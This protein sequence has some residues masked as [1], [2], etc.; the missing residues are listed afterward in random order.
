M[1]AR[2]R[3]L[4]AGIVLSLSI[5]TW[6]GIGLA[7]CPD[8]GGACTGE[9]D[10]GMKNVKDVFGAIECEHGPEYDPDCG[11]RPRCCEQQPGGCTGAADECSCFGCG[12]D[13][14][15]ESDFNVWVCGCGQCTTYGFTRPAG[16]G[17]PCD[18]CKPA[19][20]ADAI[21]FEARSMDAAAGQF[22][23]AGENFWMTW[24]FWCGDPHPGPMLVGNCQA[25][26]DSVCVYEPGST[27]R[28]LR[29]GQRHTCQ[30]GM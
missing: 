29:T 28:T 21:L 7:Q 22:C 8:A 18:D 2:Q 16:V 20:A 23:D 27:W 4:L 26:D 17:G 1:T 30:P 13:P 24:V 14:D 9:C 6:L 11:E 25:I 12:N 3:W 15:C 19:G 5:T 10:H